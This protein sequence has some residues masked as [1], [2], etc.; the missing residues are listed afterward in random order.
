MLRQLGLDAVSER[1]YRSM[2][3]NRDW[4]MNELSGN[5][6]LPRADVAVAIGK[7]ERLDLVRR[8]K[9][10]PGSL[11]IV[12]PEIG[13]HSLLRSQQELLLKKQEEFL[14]T[15]AAVAGLLA[16]LPPTG[17]RAEVEQLTGLDEVHHRLAIV[18][19]ESEEECLSL[20]PGRMGTP[21]AIVAGAELCQE[22]LARGTKVRSIYIDSARNDQPTAAHAAELT[23]IGAELRTAPVVPVRMVVGD[24]RAALVSSN[25]ELSWSSA[26]Y[27][28]GAAVV[29]ALIAF[30]E[31]LWSGAVPFCA[32]LPVDSRG[33]SGQEREML[34]LLARGTTDDA[35]AK[36]LGVSLRTVR[37]MM[38]D[39]MDRLGARSRFEAGLRVAELGWLD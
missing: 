5:L 24:R 1:I 23:E 31:Q 21:A 18:A 4:G 15:Q 2:V 32:R 9:E 14:A 38:A 34:K 25:P 10:T 16:D 11:R 30:F 26:V 13:L 8:S 7:L 17:H 29:S 19:R 22:A 36:R 39:L 27:L 35:V 37:R 3:E 33:L 20:I 28:S 6:E 12:D